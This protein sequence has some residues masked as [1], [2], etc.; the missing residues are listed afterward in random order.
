MTSITTGTGSALRRGA[1]TNETRV[2]LAT[3]A[4]SHARPP[5]WP[6]IRRTGGNWLT[7]RKRGAL[8]AV[9]SHQR[10]T[11]IRSEGEI[12]GARARAQSPVRLQLLTNTHTRARARS[13]VHRFMYDANTYARRRRVTCYHR[14]YRDSR[15]CEYSE[16][17]SNDGCGGSPAHARCGCSAVTR[18]RHARPNNGTAQCCVC[19]DSVL[20]GARTVVEI[21]NTGD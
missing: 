10:S 3:F 14:A 7:E 16:V 8:P 20:D 6:L 2:K 19:G 4:P 5:H 15:A 17:A 18:V 1:D 9:T 13:R 12:E 11:P 21:S